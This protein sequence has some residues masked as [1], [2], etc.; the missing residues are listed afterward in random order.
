MNEVWR[1]VRTLLKSND[2]GNIGK[3]CNVPNNKAIREN[4]SEDSVLLENAAIVITALRGR[5]SHNDRDLFWDAQYAFSLY[6]LEKLFMFK[7]GSV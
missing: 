4:H 7:T 3:R 2:E 1:K 6:R 5:D